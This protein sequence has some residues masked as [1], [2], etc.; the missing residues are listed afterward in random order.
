MR[1]RND[2]MHKKPEKQSRLSPMVMTAVAMALIAAALLLAPQSAS[3]GDE[4]ARQAAAADS[5]RVAEGCELLQTL[6]YTRCEHSVTR[7]VAAPVEIIGKTLDEVRPLYDGWQ[8]TEFSASLIKMTQQPEIHCPDHMVLLPD[9]TGMLCVFQNRYGDALALVSELSTQ[10]AD[11]PAAMQ[12]EVRDGLGFAT[13][14][15]L[16]Q[17]LESAES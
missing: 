4:A 14:G 11:L 2:P 15:E 7:R 17:W 8:I 1:E 13:L 10:L 5:V 3:Q 6:T 12:E 16:E 9:E